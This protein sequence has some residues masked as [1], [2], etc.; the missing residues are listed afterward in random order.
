MSLAISLRVFLS[1]GCL[2]SLGLLAI[3]VLIA[4]IASQESADTHSACPHCDRRV[5]RFTEV[6]PHCGRV[7]IEDD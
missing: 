7:L 1:L 2:A 3:V 4:A 5:P 6:C